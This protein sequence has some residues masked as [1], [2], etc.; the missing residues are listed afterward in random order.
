M[1]R[2]V[3]VFVYMARPA[4]AARRRSAPRQLH[5]YPDHRLVP[6]DFG[7]IKGFDPVMADGILDPLVAFWA[8]WVAMETHFRRLASARS[9][10][11]SRPMTSCAPTTA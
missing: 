8:D 4:P 1:T 3:E 7:C 6:L 9:G 10:A 2:L 11:A 5:V